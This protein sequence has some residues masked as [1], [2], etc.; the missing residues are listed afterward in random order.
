MY[1]LSTENGIIMCY[2]HELKKKK[3]GVGQESRKRGKRGEKEDE[4]ELR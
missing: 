4:K 3:M 2:N 1:E